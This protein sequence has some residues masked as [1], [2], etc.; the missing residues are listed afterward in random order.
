MNELSKKISLADIDYKELSGNLFEFNITINNEN[1]AGSFK[2]TIKGQDKNTGLITKESSKV[3]SVSGLS[4]KNFIVSID[5]ANIDY[6]H[7]YA[8]EKNDVIEAI[9]TDNYVIVPFIKIKPKAYLVINTE[10]SKADEAIKGYLKLF[11]Q[12]VAENQAEFVIAVGNPNFNSKVNSYNSFTRTNL[13]FYYD[14]TNKAPYFNGQKVV[15][16]G[17][18]GLVGRFVNNSGSNIIIAYGN[19]IEGDVAAVKKLISL[20]ETFLNKNVFGQQFSQFAKFTSVIDRYD[21]IGLEVMDLVHNRENHLYYNS[22]SGVN[23]ERFRDVVEDILLDNNYE[24]AI[25]T[26][27]TTSGTSYGQNTTLRLKNLNSD[28]SPLFKDAIITN[29]KPIVMSGGI[30]S[31]LTT[32]EKTSSGSLALGGELAQEGYDVWTIEMNGGLCIIEHKNE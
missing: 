7:V 20:K 18:V 30:F 22:K 4:T 17:Y 25:K 28:F 1:V 21:R 31:D 24:I 32:F 14:K 11:V 16:L 8:D 2:V 15:G 10:N 23:G 3:E 9:E 6:F 29:S 26:V 12:E 19:G 13:G 27:Q 5:A